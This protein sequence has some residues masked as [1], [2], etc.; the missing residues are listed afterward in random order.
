MAK[1]QT[2]C[3]DKNSAVAAPRMT[4]AEKVATALKHASSQAKKQLAQQGLKLPTQS[5]A[6]ARV[7]NPV[8]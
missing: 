3:P 7:R 2:T 5:W 4:P 6:N 8:V 1:S